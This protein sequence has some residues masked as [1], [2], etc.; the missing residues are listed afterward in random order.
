MIETVLVNRDQYF[1]QICINYLAKGSYVSEL[2]KTNAI[3]AF[4]A[5]VFSGIDKAEL[6]L[7]LT[8]SKDYVEYF[9][10]FGAASFDRHELTGICG[11]KRLGVVIVTK[12][13]RCKEIP[14]D[15]HVIEEANIDG[16]INW[17]DKHGSVYE[18]IP[19][20]KPFKCAH[21]MYDFYFV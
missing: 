10:H 1:G 3:H 20:N 16:I 6:A 2:K 8:F 9:K 18:T 11:S 19:G 7:G 4:G 17:Q 12:R 15:W 13:F 5:I 14:S 21:K